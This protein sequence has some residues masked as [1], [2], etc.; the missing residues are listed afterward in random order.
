MAHFLKYSNEHLKKCVDAVICWWDE[1]GNPYFSGTSHHKNDGLRSFRMIE[2]VGRYEYVRVSGEH[3][4]T[5]F[6]GEI[7]KA[8]NFKIL[9]VEYAQRI[10]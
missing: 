7:R 6:T 9:V 1:A 10:R 2:V 5:F 3:Y 8:A 4:A